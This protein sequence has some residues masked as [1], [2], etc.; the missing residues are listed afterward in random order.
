MVDKAGLGVR[1]DHQGGY[2]EAIALAADP[3]RL[4]VLRTIG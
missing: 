4:D 2:P 3:G 1:A